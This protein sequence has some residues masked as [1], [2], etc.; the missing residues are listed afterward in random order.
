[1]SDV[2]RCDR[3]RRPL[4]S[5]G[6]MFHSTKSYSQSKHYICPTNTGYAV[7]ET[8][9]DVPKQTVESENA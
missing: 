5:H 3:C 8:V 9:F 7:S 6:T 4:D 1:M 2:E